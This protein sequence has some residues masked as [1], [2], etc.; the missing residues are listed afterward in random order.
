M[1]PTLRW[2]IIGPGWIA[3]RFVGAVQRN[4]AQTVLAVGSRGADRSAAFAAKH[5]IERSYGSYEALLADPDVDVVYV[6]TPHNAHFPC[7]RLAV[8]AGKHTVVEKPL[9]LN[10]SQAAELRDLAQ[11]RGVFVMEALWTMFLP[12]FDVIRRLLADGALGDVN[13]V[14]AD[15]GEYFEAG[16]RILRHDLAGGPMLDLGTYPVSFAGFVLGPFDEVRALGQ[17]HPAGVNGQVSAVLATS[18]GAQAVVNT[19]VLANTPTTGSIAGTAATLA[20]AGPFYQPGPMTLTSVSGQRLVYDEPA[21]G[22]E[23]LFYEAAEAA[24][25]IADGRTESPLR[26]LADSI[27]TLTTMDE[28]RRQIEQVFDEER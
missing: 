11:S 4:T 10:A 16:H 2:G 14:L 6:A 26:P 13:T 8:A 15:H 7:A 19:T 21:I 9:A 17:P 3:E 5:G 1:A 12:K 28:I 18:T 25:C 20:I 22:H 27:A 23:G 24:R